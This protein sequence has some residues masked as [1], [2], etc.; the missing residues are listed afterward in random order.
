M[1][2]SDG[3][4]CIGKDKRLFRA[5]LRNPLQRTH[6]LPLSESKFAT[7]FSLP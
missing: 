6:L 2:E 1:A 4:R 5:L 3:V 7:R